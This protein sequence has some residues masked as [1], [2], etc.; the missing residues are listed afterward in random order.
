VGVAVV[1]DSA[2]DLSI[3]DA[4]SLGVQVVPLVVTFG[5]DS[6]RD[7]LD[8]AP[9]EFWRLAAARHPT[10]AA[11]SPAAF[12]EAYRRAA[13]DGAVAA[14]AVHV[15]GEVSSVLQQA[16]DAARDAPLPV[17]VIDSRQV[18]PGQALVVQEASRAAAEG[19]DAAGVAAAAEA[20][21][22][23]VR[24][25]ALV[26]SI[27]FLRR[28]GRVGVVKAVVSDLLRVRPVLTMDH[29]RPALVAKARTR[30]RALEEVLRRLAAPGGVAVAGRVAHALAPD[31]EAVVART[32]EALGVPI[33][34][35]VMGAATGSHLGPGAVAVA[36][37]R[38]PG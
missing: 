1:T 10:T 4:T 7:G 17:R 24:V 8:L 18:G 21:A 36:V 12:A 35:T 32:R 11:P 38:R 22:G 5:T 25:L 19:R 37:L 2:A 27:E 29:G 28:G 33:S 3:A 31:A 9:Q 23:L 14:V 34:V 6:Y 30:A 13:E 16:T 26:E 20:T 15:S